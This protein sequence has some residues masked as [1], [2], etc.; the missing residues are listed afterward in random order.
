MFFQFFFNYYFQIHKF[1][2]FK[3]FYD[4]I[5]TQS[6]YLERSDTRL[7]VLVLNIIYSLGLLYKT[8]LYSLLYCLTKS[9]LFFL[10]IEIELA[11]FKKWY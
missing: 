6:T 4:P 3:A 11:F 7:L 2:A 9:F 8:F 5:E 10:N 1:D